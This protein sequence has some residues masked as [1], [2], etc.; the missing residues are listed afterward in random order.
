M[1]VLELSETVAIIH[2]MALC[3]ALDL[4][5]L[6]AR[7]ARGQ[8]LHSSVRASCAKHTDDRAMDGVIGV[9]LERY[10]KGELPI[11]EIDFA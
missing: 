1:R 11:G 10:H 2:L 7:H 4:R 8:A 9:L 6:P 5:G 3:Q